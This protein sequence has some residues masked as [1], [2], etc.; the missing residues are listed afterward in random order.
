MHFLRNP[1]D[2]DAS[3]QDRED[4]TA[5]EYNSG[6]E[7]MKRQS[8]EENNMTQYLFFFFFKF[9]QGVLGWGRIC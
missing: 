3:W 9:G 4:E 6:G 1:A 5:Y 8:R 2:G 7:K